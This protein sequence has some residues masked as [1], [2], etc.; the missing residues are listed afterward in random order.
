MFSTAGSALAHCDTLDGPVISQA[1]Q[2]LE[3]GD[4]KIV[5]P[6]RGGGQGEG[7]PGGVR[8]GGGCA[9]EGAEGEKSSRTGISSRHWCASTGK[10]KEPLPRAEA[11]GMDLAPP[12]RRQTRRWSPATPPA[13][14]PHQRKVHEGIHKY[15][16]AAKEKKAHA[17]ESV[18]AGRAYVNAYVPYLHFVERL[19]T[20]PLPD[21]PRWRRRGTCGASGPPGAA[22]ALRPRTG[23]RKRSL[24]EV[25][26][27][28]A[29]PNGREGR[30]AGKPLLA[31]CAFIVVLA[32][33]FPAYRGWATE[34]YAGKRAGNAWVPP[35]PLGRRG[36]QQ[37]WKAFLA[38]RAEAGKNATRF[39]PRFTAGSGSPPASFTC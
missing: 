29:W 25:R 36:A 9:R 23:G 37:C 27:D 19:Y 13:P 35:R 32:L 8:S 34:D 33:S 18:E 17:G 20:M 4:V 11:A 22:R 28:L 21:C 3:K 31:L 15:Y 24:Q 39:P 38:G 16:M 1:R 7:D 5:L 10:G 26:R 14:V 30:Y 12:Y 2:A 6:W